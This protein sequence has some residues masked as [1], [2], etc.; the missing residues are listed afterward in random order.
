[1]PAK[2]V[3][4]KYGRYH[5]HLIKPKLEEIPA[6]F[7]VK[8][9]ISPSGAYSLHTEHSGEKRELSTN[10]LLL[11]LDEI[12]QSTKNGYP[13]LWHS[14]RWSEQ[15]GIFLRRLVDG[16]KNPTFI[17]IHPP[18][19]RDVPS[20]EKFLEIYESFEKYVN[21]HF[22]STQ[23]VIENRTSSG[24]GYF[25]IRTQRDI[26]A[27]LKTLKHGKYRLR[28]VL[29]IPQLITTFKERNVETIISAL[30]KL[31]KYREYI[32]GIHLYGKK[33]MGELHTLFG[34]NTTP[35]SEKKKMKTELLLFLSE[36][37]NDDIARYLVPEVNSSQRVLNSVLKDLTLFFEFV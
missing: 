8:R 23:I 7:N 17:E 14:K 12:I 30:Q 11:G 4:V 10:P 1:M 35:E 36:F 2:F 37:F 31:E 33:H 19:R 5:Y 13:L 29:D 18:Y 27:F 26:L 20:V 3:L 32:L 6:T 22:P 34:D 21:A 15:F 25:L 24:A 28:L 9:R 16:N